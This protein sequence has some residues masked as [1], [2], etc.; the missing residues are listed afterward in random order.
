MG[1]RRSSRSLR[2]SLV[3]AIV[4]GSV[5]LGLGIVSS[6]A[7]AATVFSAASQGSQKPLTLAQ[8]QAKC[9]QINQTFAASVTQAQVAYKQATKGKVSA[10][11]VSAANAALNL[12][13]ATATKIRDAA[14]QAL[15]PRPNR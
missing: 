6:S 11:A 5:V 8:W 12:A 7:E 3:R 1:C 2:T 14:L 15:G 13:I 9:D 10:A 4:A